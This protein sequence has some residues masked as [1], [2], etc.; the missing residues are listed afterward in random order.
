LLTKYGFT[1][2]DVFNAVNKSN[3]NV[4]GDIIEKNEQAFVVRGIG[5]LN[6]IEEIKN[7]IITNINNVPILVRNVAEVKESGKP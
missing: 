5:L 4:G 3:V 1:A 7:I 2:L 6:N